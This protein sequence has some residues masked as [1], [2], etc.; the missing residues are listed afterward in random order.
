MG[1]ASP[2]SQRQWMG[3]QD[4]SQRGLYSWLLTCSWPV[5]ATCKCTELRISHVYYSESSVIRT[6]IIR[7]LDYPDATRV[8]VLMKGQSSHVISP[9]I[10]TCTMAIVD[11]SS[12]SR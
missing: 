12:L 6:S 1:S 5:L 8:R 9:R 3:Y 7:I 4:S 10:C 2:V 11:S